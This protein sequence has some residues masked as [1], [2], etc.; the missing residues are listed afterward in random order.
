MADDVA[1]LVAV[2]EADMRGFT[3]GMEQA[4]A[5]A[6]QKFGAIERTL[7]HTESRFKTFGG[8]LAGFNGILGKFL[9]VAAIEEFSR[10]VLTV[11]A[12]LV[13]Q[14]RVVGVSVEALQAFRGVMKDAGGSA[15][16]ADQLLRRLTASI[17]DAKDGATAATNAFG[18]LKLGPKDIEGSTEEVLTRVAKALLAIPDPAQRARVEIELFKRS[19]QEFERVLPQLADGL[20]AVTEKLREQQR[21]TGSDTAEQ[22]RKSLSDLA[23]A[24]SQVQVAASDPIIY[25]LHGFADLINDA[26]A[27]GDILNRLP[28]DSDLLHGRFTHTPMP[29]LPF[30][31]AET[32]ALSKQASTSGAPFETEEQK[33]AAKAAEEAAKRAEEARAIVARTV[34][35]ATRAAEAVAKAIAAANV[36]ITSGTLSSF[37]DIRKQIDINAAAELAITEDD[38]KSKIAA[39]KD[40]KGEHKAYIEATNHLN[41]EAASRES[42]IIIKQ[43]A[44]HLQADRDELESR[45]QLNQAVT[46]QRRTTVDSQHGLL[47]ELAQGTQDYYKLAR[48]LSDESAKYEEETI[49][50]RLNHD[51]EVLA[52][53]KGTEEERAAATARAELEIEAVHNRAAANTVRLT[54]EETHAREHQIEVMDRVRGGLEDI[55]AAALHGAKSFKDAAL[56]MLEQLAEMSLRLYILRPLIESVFGPAGTVGGGF[57]GD[58]L[59]STPRKFASGGRPPAGQPSIVGENGPELFW[60]DA[61]GTI[62]PNVPSARPSSAGQIEVAVSVHPSG[63]F[64]TRVERVSGGVVARAAPQIVQASVRQVGRNLGPMMQD[65]SRRKF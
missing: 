64:D 13:D 35:E 48:E 39:L 16:D 8:G 65:T 49:R 34:S 61:A 2:M 54:E 32:I 3:K 40:I 4:Q 15:D 57:L 36:D 58:L 26:K 46:E 9:S 52:S 17:G 18:L 47:L 31:N 6:D 42:A 45:Y 14:A 56:Q 50:D 30:A 28:T 24:W 11:T 63:E 41:D 43:R 62:V 53:H 23:E 44:E 21:L 22:A 5:I 19:G 12:G 1:R 38:R 51:L 20:G 60:P 27:L 55:G 25:M 33:K 10:H 7:T 29:Q 37:A 59:G